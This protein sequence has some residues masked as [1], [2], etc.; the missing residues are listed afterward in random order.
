MADLVCEDCGCPHDR[1]LT[2]ISDAGDPTC[3]DC[4]G[5]L[6]PP[7]GRAEIDPVA[8]GLLTL[9]VGL[10]LL[11]GFGILVAGTGVF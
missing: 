4:G 7:A 2:G 8:L 6:S 3:I 10:V 5:P 11:V 9:V 1:G